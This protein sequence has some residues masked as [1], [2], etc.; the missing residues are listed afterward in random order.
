MVNHLAIHLRTAKQ[1]GKLSSLY[2]NQN[3]WT[4]NHTTRPISN[5]QKQHR[6]FFVNKTCIKMTMA[7]YYAYI[8]QLF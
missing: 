8:G 4:M 3:R 1:N 6:H 2:H 7:E 5:S